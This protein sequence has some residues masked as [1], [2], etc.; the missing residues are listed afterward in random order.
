MSDQKVVLVLGAGSNIGQ[1]TSRAFAAKGYKVALASR[2]AKSDEDTADLKHF[3][4]DLSKSSSIPE[5][6]TKVKEALGI[7]SVVIYNGNHNSFARHSHLLTISK[8]RRSHHQ[9]ARQHLLHLP[10]RFR[11]KPRHQHYQ[12]ICR[13]PTSHTWI[14]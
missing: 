13:R 7:P 8:S 14:R 10:H 4:T 11:E 12:P 3:P 1:S 9:R 6:F 2:S 5:L